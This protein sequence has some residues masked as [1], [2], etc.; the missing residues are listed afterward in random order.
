VY[1][2]QLTADDGE[3]SGTATHTVTVEDTPGPDPVTTVT[4]TFS[5]SL[6]KKFATRTYEVV[7]GDGPLDAVLSFD[8]KPKGNKKGATA[9]EM[10]LTLVDGGGNVI[11]SA[12]GGTPVELSLELLA[13]GGYVLEVS[14]SQISFDL[15]VTHA[16]L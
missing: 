4:E 12:T 2:L 6:N 14:G 1:E 7:V 5:G 3:L 16:P 10:S 9:Y 11:A 13:Q 8:E 15:D